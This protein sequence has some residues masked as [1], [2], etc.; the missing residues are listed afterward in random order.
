MRV[1]YELGTGLLLA[2]SNDFPEGIVTMSLLKPVA[3]IL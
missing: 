2:S 3:E 1:E